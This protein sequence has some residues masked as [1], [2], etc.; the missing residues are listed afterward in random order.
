MKKVLLGISILLIGLGAY[1]QQDAQWSLN[2]F[3]RLST[4]PGVAGSNNAVCATL[5]GRQQWVQFDGRPATYQF[6]VHGPL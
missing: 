3:N 1:A 5:L 6:T 2:T 4:N